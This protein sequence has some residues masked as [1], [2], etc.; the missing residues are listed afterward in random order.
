MKR[1]V[2]NYTRFVNERRYGPSEEEL[3]S[4]DAKRRRLEK[5]GIFPS[6]EMMSG[7]EDYM[8]EH[9]KGVLINLIR[10]EKKNLEKFMNLLEEE[11]SKSPRNERAIDILRIHISS[12]TRAIDFLADS[13]YK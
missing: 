12:A 9:H 5:G 4:L 8:K 7:E 2:K 6:P 11:E 3:S 1:L 13:L 10:S